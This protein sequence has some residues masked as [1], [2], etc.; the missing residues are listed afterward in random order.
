[1]IYAYYS[2]LSYSS[3]HP[4]DAYDVVYDDA[5]DAFTIFTHS[6]RF[7]HYLACYYYY[8]YL[9][10]NKLLP[11]RRRAIITY[12]TTCTTITARD[13]IAFKFNNSYL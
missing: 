13:F 10:L 11:I 6:Y 2:C 9:N 1:M 3:F 4:Y 12:S 8:Y 5:Y 7:N